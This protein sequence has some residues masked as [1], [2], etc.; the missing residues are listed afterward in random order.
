MHISTPV[1]RSPFALARI[2]KRSGASLSP[3]ERIRGSCFRAR[4]SISP[5]PSPTPD[6]IIPRVSGSNDSVLPEDIIISATSPEDLRPWVQSGRI[7]LRG[8]AAR[9]TQ[10][11]A[12]D[13]VSYDD[14]CHILSEVSLFLED[15]RF[16]LTPRRG[17][18]LLKDALVALD[19]IWSDR[20]IPRYEPPPPSGVPVDQYFR[21]AEAMQLI[22][23]TVRMRPDT[24]GADL[25]RVGL[26]RSMHQ[27]YPGQWVIALFWDHEGGTV[28]FDRK[29]FQMLMVVDEPISSSSMWALDNRA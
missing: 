12:S 13:I 3:L 15:A 20:E 28:F 9:L 10:E 29:D 6:A 1:S 24:P 23:V 16:V 25:A 14:A 27:L 22:G 5:D 7:S 19:C 21:A 2:W 4:N 8:I 11:G 26:V 18:L 17:A